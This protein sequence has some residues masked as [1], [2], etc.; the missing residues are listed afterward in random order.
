MRAPHVLVA[1][2]RDREASTPREATRSR[3]RRA[4]CKGVFG[5][6]S[7]RLDSPNRLL[8]DELYG[9]EINTYRKRGRA[10]AR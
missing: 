10:F 5:T 6:L 8:A 7:L 1:R 2:V 9:L 3:C 4:A